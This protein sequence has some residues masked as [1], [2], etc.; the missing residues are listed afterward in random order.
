MPV[1]SPTTG[2]AANR[3]AQRYK[4][5]HTYAVWLIFDVMII[6]GS[7]LLLVCYAIARHYHHVGVFCDISD[8]VRHMPERVLFR[9]NF[10]LIGSMLVAMAYPVHDIA[11]R[12]VGGDLPGRGAILQRV[13]G[14]GVILVGACGPGECLWFHNYAA[15]MGFGGSGIAQILYA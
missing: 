3:L 13:S 9:F 10:A 1:C 4:I 5:Y 7:V 8:L 14:I 2:L 11:A 6:L 15:I 12:R